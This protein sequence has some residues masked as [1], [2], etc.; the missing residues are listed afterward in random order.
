VIWRYDPMVF[1]T[2]TGP[3]FHRQAYE[4]IARALRGRTRRSVVSI[5]DLYRKTS[6]RLADLAVHGVEFLP[7]DPTP[8]EWFETLMRDLVCTAHDNDMEIVSCA[9]PLDL[10]PYGIR[11]GKCVDDAF[12][13]ETFGLDVTRQKDP[14]QRAACSCVASKDIGMYDA[15]LFG[16]RYCYATSSFERARENYRAHRPDSPSLLGWYERG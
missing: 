1:S 3:D 8:G 7:V 16:C 15:C 4:Q 10:E 12:I 9:E 13:R 5:M 11:P 6:K 14:S 2:I